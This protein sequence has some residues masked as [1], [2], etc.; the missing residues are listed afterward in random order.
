MAASP[1]KKRKKRVTRRK[2]P[3][4]AGS[5][6]PAT[7]KKAAAPAKNQKVVKRSAKKRPAEPKSPPGVGRRAKRG[8]QGKRLGDWVLVKKQDVFDFMARNNIGHSAMGRALGVSPTL[9]TRWKVGDRIPSEVAQQK[10]QKL[11]AGELPVETAGR[12]GGASRA[13]GPFDPKALQRWREEQRLSRKALAKKLEVSPGS[14]FGWEHGRTE[15]TGVNRAR[16]EE[17]MQ[18]AA[19]VAALPAPAAGPGRPAPG[20][21]DATMAAAIEAAGRVVAAR[22]GAG[23]KDSPEALVKLARQLRDAL[24]T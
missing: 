20:R 2:A 17:L 6:K 10:L 21:T 16:L 23:A 7:K 18:A 1:G 13:A 12:G 8:R 11:L 19:P 5:D 15:P 4:K 3:A 9:L 24:L 14:I 22:A